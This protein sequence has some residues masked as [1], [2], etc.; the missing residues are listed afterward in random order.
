MY[1]I[2]SNFHWRSRFDSRDRPENWHCTR[3]FFSLARFESQ[4]LRIWTKEK[5]HSSKS[6]WRLCYKQLWTSYKSTAPDRVPSASNKVSS[7]PLW[8]AKSLTLSRH[9]CPVAFCSTSISNTCQSGRQIWHL[10]IF[11]S[12][13]NTL[14]QV[15][16]FQYVHIFW[17]NPVRFL[18]LTT[19]LVRS[20]Q[21]SAHFWRSRVTCFQCAPRAVNLAAQPIG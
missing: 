14:T 3:P 1:S 17:A 5:T 2:M 10:I 4:V 9:C 7:P 19:L 15:L 12:Q 11:T 18:S 13:E 6:C 8:L 21:G 20:Q 16:K